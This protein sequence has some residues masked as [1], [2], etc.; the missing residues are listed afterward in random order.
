MVKRKIKQI[1]QLEKRFKSSVTKEI[2][3]RWQA[4]FVSRQL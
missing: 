2:F 1:F 4:A 3:D